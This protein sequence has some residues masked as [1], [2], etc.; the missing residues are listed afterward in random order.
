MLHGTCVRCLEAVRP[1][2]ALVPGRDAGLWPAAAAAGSGSR[3][4]VGAWWRRDA[5]PR[6]GP[7][8]PFGGLSSG[9]TVSTVPLGSRVARLARRGRHGWGNSGLGCWVGGGG[10]QWGRAAMDVVAQG[11][12]AAGVL[13]ALGTGLCFH[14]RAVAGAAPAAL[15]GGFLGLG[16]LVH[17]G[18]SQGVWASPLAGVLRSSKRNRPIDY[19]SKWYLRPDHSKSVGVE[20]LVPSLLGNS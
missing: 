18:P 12:V 15:A 6:G 9:F 2:F 5:G 7:G 8:P 14:R 11:A 17:A 10:L 4:P 19:R 1:G 16:Q 13:G 3:A 20:A